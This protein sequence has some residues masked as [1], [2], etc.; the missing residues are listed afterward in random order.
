MKKIFSVFTILAVS[1]MTFTSC[2][3]VP[4]PY[5]Y[6]GRSNG[7]EPGVVTDDSVYINATFASDFTP[8]TA[9]T[10]LG[11]AWTIDSHHYAKATGHV[12][13]KN[14]PSTPSNAFLV[15][16]PV[17]LTKSKSAYVKFEYML[18]Y[19]T[20][21]GKSKEGVA[22]RVLI[23][24]NYTGDPTTTTWTE[25]IN[26]DKMTEGSDWNT[27]YSAAVDLP[28]QFI[29]K[30]N[31]VVALQ[32]TCTDN[33]ATW[34][35]RNF[36]LHEG[37]AP[38]NP[39]PGGGTTTGEAKGEGSLENPFNSVAANAQAL[40]GDTSEV[41]VKGKISQISE[42]STKFGNATYFISDDGTTN[43]QFEIFRG[44]YLKGEKFTSE[45]QIK[46]GQT[47]VVKGKLTVYRSTPQMAQG[48]QIVSID[49][50]GGSTGGESGSIGTVSGNTITFTATDCG[51]ENAADIGTIV[52]KDG[53]KLTFDIGQGKYGPK[54]YSAGGGALRVYPGNTITVSSSKSIASIAFTCDS[55]NGTE[56]TAEGNVKVNPGTFALDG[57]TMNF[58]NINATSTV[59]T[60]AETGS[61]G[62]TQMRIKSV[63]ITYAK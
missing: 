14:T 5:D 60:N 37:T 7:G 45:D 16:T 10:P 23:T 50:N 9:V 43:G 44:Y 33:S 40:A 57:L 41:Y 63:V 6:P 30:N 18:C 56:Y 36:I 2:E 22:D 52:L 12:N 28:A 31:V 29:G 32:Y 38:E 24:D 49:N 39:N 61:G 4:S 54:F 11:V 21:H 19:Y 1:A 35:V 42:V 8:F 3:D 53:T 20:N 48:S 51:L 27:W 15:S 25:V 62:K 26:G 58:T 59:I 17:D 13:G 46:V 47:V 34:E 55:A